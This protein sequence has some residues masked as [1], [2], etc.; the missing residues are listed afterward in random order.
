MFHT[1][2][3]EYTITIQG[4]ELVLGLSVDG[5]PIT[6]STNYEYMCHSLL[7][8]TLNN[9]AFKDSGLSLP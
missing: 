6:R 3:R 9:R 4:M 8:V 2:G 1:S 5:E 7:Y